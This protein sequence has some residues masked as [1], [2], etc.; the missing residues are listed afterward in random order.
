[1]ELLREG[2]VPSWCTACYRKVSGIFISGFVLGEQRE[3]KRGREKM[4]VRRTKKKKTFAPSLLRAAVAAAAARPPSLHH[5]PFF[6]FTLFF[7]T[8]NK[9]SLSRG[10]PAKPS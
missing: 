9:N 7:Y 3:G 10:A 1:M 6:F 8:Q 4:G 2:Y 5:Q